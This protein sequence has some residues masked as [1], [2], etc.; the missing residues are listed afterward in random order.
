VALCQVLLALVPSPRDPSSAHLAAVEVGEDQTL[1]GKFGDILSMKSSNVLR[2]GFLNIGGLSP[3]K[4]NFKDDSLRHGIS[5]HDFDVFGLAKTNFDWHLVREEDRLYLRT[6]EWWESVH[7]SLTHNHTMT[8]IANKR[9]GGTA[10]FSLNQASHR[11]IDKGCDPTNLGRWC[12]A[13]YR[14]KNNHL[15]RVFSAY[16]PNPLQSVFSQH[17][18][19][20]LPRHL[21]IKDLV[22]EVKKAQ[23]KGE[24]TIIMLDGNFDMRQSMMAS[25]FHS[26]NLRE[27]I[28]HRHGAN[29]PS[30]FH[31]NTTNTP[32]DGIWVSSG[33]SIL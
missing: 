33:I 25:S 10:L 8:P 11:V 18:L 4:N 20:L 17:R 6:K 30:T 12:G 2:I 32:I 16:C 21:F 3:Q 29:G 28:L 15:L 13:L 23:S 9:W 26:A 24:H 7:L 22:K 31:R 19:F 14:G 27:A 1:C 5:A